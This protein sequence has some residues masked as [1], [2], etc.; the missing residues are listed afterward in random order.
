MGG[1]HH[2]GSCCDRYIVSKQWLY[3]PYCGGALL[4]GFP[5]E[6][7]PKPDQ[8]ALAQTDWTCIGGKN[9]CKRKVTKGEYCTYHWNRTPAGQNYIVDF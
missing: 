9:G 1:R 2:Y 6:I 7:K 8:V 3:C 5:L 4:D